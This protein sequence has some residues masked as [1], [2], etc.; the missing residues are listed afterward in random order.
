[1]T[2]IYIVTYSDNYYPQEGT[3]DWHSVHLDF[4]KA[5]EAFDALVAEQSKRVMSPNGGAYLIEI[6]Q[7]GDDVVW[8]VSECERA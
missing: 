8:S 4:D 5:A 7:D 3:A 2:S 6:M 1:M